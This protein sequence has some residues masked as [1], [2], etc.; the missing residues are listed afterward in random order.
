[1][2]SNMI[3]RVLIGALVLYLVLA[4]V[5]IGTMDT[6]L[7]GGAIDDV[8]N[9]LIDVHELIGFGIFPVGLGVVVVIL[10]LGIVATGSGSSD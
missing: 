1:V 2:K 4:G 8:L 7:G 5:L 10:I 3:R 9:G 6:G